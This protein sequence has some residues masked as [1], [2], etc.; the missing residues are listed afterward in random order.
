MG[1]QQTTPLFDHLVGPR[2]QSAHFFFASWRDLLAY[3]SSS[4]SLMTAGSRSSSRSSSS[5][6]SS[7]S[8]GSRG[9]MALPLNVVRFQSIHVGKL[10]GM[11]EAMSALL[12]S[13]NE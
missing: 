9:G 1:S 7:S 8:S 10:M 11:G 2:R 4:G 12:P 5:S 6:S 3:S 13:N